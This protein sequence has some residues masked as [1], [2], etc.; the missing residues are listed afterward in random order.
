MPER[1]I[2]TGGLLYHHASLRSD[3]WVVHLCEFSRGQSQLNR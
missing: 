1:K 3:A 2:I